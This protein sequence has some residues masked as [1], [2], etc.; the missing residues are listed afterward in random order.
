MDPSSRLALEIVR[1]MRKLRDGRLPAPGR[2]AE[3]RSSG[4]PAWSVPCTVV[5]LDHLTV[6]L[7]AEGPLPYLLIGTPVAVVP[8][9]TRSALTATLVEVLDPDHILVRLE[10]LAERR[11]DPRFGL[12]LN[13]ALDPLDRHDEVPLEGVTV[14]LSQGGARIR[15]SRPVIAGTRALL[16]LDL[17]GDGVISAIVETLGGDVEAD[18]GGFDARLR[19]VFMPTE[20]R[21]HLRAFLDRMPSAKAEEG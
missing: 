17:P 5:T 13:I 12:T 8:A 19:F 14:D 3:L 2:P 6:A 16:W 11:A 18:I 9:S 1:E 20:A 21:D 4:A 15:L 7:H 10:P